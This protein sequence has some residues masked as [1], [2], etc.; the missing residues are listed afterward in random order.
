MTMSASPLAIAS[1]SSRNRLTPPISEESTSVRASGNVFR[2]PR[3]CVRPP[4]R[5]RPDGRVSRIPGRHSALA[6][7]SRTGGIGSGH[8]SGARP[9]NSNIA[10][11]GSGGHRPGR[12]S[13]A[14]NTPIQEEAK[15]LFARSTALPTE[16]SST[17]ERK[18]PRSGGAR[19]MSM[20]CRSGMAASAKRVGRWMRV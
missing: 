19:R 9:A 5:K 18:P 14:R 12:A 3:R 6:R 10:G 7:D 1:S 8:G 15:C 2:P 11:T 16:R 13:A 20:R 4:G 17:G